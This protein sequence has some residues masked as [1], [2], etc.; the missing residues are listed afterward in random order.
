MKPLARPILFPPGPLPW[1]KPALFT[2]S[3]TP[4]A[5]MIARALRGTLGADPVAV[6][7]NQLGLLALIFLVA[8]LACTPLQIV[9]SVGFPIRVRRMLGLFSFFYASLHVLVYAVVDQGLRLAAIAE[10]V[11]KRPFIFVGLSAFLL[12]LPLAATSTARMIKAMGY[13]RWK[14]LHRLAYVTAAL[15][16]VHF[17]LR[18]KKDLTE[19]TL[20]AVALGA[21]FAIRIAAYLVRR[22]R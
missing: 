15:A 21:L 4:L 14:L 7:L 5:V 1:L 13:A 19:P 20:Y 16:V 2:G 11:G 8:S 22:A 17:V 18:V 10:D 3:L 12:L 9:F 6:G